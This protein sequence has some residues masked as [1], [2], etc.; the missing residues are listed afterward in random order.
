MEGKKYFLT[1]NGKA[2][3]LLLRCIVD[4]HKGTVFQ[5]TTKEFAKYSHQSSFI[6]QLANSIHKKSR[7][8]KS[9]KLF[10]KYF[11]PFF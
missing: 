11:N 9:I 10:D 2:A 8:Y 7:Y 5:I 4:N 3:E 6:L 1:T